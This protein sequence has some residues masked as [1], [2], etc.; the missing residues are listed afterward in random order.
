MTGSIH[1]GLAP[2]WAKELGK[3]DLVALQ[4]SA[5]TGILYCRVENESVFIAGNCVNYLE[6]TIAIDP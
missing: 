5:R 6:G 4:A 1:T 3:T 2:Y